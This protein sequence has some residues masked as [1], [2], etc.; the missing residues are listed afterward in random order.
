MSEKDFYLYID[1]Q[2]VKVSEEIYRVYKSAEEKERYFMKRLKK[3]RFVMDPEGREGIYVPGREKS[4]E[5][6]LD[7]EWEFADQGMSVEDIVEKASLIKE[8]ETAMRTL[9]EDERVLIEEIFYLERTEREVCDALHM[10]KTT[11][12]RRKQ[13]I[14][15]KLKEQMGKIKIIFF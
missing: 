5:K 15:R 14:L 2:N 9:S 3:G 10:A 6:L 11:L 8:L 1:G 4:F 12:N 7:E 13:A